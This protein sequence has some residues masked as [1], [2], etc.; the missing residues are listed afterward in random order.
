MK[1]LSDITNMYQLPMEVQQQQK[2][3][4]Q[5][6]LCA[7]PYHWDQLAVQMLSEL[8]QNTNYYLSASDLQM[9][10]FLFK[11]VVA[12]CRLTLDLKVSTIEHCLKLFDLFIKQKGR[13]VSSLDEA[14]LTLLTCLFISCKYQEIYPPS[15]TDFE[16]VCKYKFLA[17]D[18]L[19]L[20][21]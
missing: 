5:F 1:N 16:Y 11:W 21:L 19:K 15:I 14:K 9:R 12:K 13:F 7:G 10:E 3:L 18:F 6:N 20:E 4:R 2:N 8:E 17:K